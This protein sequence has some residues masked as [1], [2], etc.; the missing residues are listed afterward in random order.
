MSFVPLSKAAHL[1]VL[2]AQHYGF[3]DR[4]SWIPLAE[5]EFH[6]AAH[7]VPIAFNLDPQGPAVGALLDAEYQLHPLV[8]EEGKWLRGYQPLA[9]RCLPFRFSNVVSDDP[10]EALEVCS[11]LGL[12][13]SLSG[14]PI[15]GPDGR[16]TR[17]LAATHRSLIKIRNTRRKLLAAVDHLIMANL[18][19]PLRNRSASASGDDGTR[20]YI[21]D[22]DR[23]HK[24]SARILAAMARQRFWSVDLAMACLFSQRLLK[25][26]FRSGTSPTEKP[27]IVSRDE[28]A[29]LTALGLNP[30]LA[31]DDTAL[32]SA[33]DLKSSDVAQPLSAIP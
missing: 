33:N 23:F 19:M 31:L 28:Q 17:S 12:T 3:I 30:D 7:F 22:G 14:T 1:H 27:P 20:L 2:P 16:L 5:S 8:S 21:V 25:P 18:L 10:L 32:F 24:T 29:E 26:E 6:L 9:L 15:L 11:D 4:V 13:S